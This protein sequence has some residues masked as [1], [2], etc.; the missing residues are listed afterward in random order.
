MRELKK[1]ETAFSKIIEKASLKFQKLK[2]RK[3]RVGKKAMM[4]KET[5]AALK[6]AF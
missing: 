6:R 5:L 2:K 1:Y 4:L 3:N